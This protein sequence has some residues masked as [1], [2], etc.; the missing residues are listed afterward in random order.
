LQVLG[1][2]SRAVMTMLLLMRLML[3]DRW[4]K[5]QLQYG[6]AAR[7]STCLILSIGAW[8]LASLAA[9][10]VRA[11]SQQQVADA[12][13]RLIAA[14]IFVG[15]LTGKDLTWHARLE[16]FLSFP[17]S[18]SR[19]YG[20]ALILSLLTF[21]VLLGFCI[22]EISV[23]ARTAG[24]SSLLFALPAFVLLLCGGRAMVSLTRT[25]LFRARALAGSVRYRL[26]SLIVLVA[27]SAVV[28]SLYDITGGLPGYQYSGIFFGIHPRSTLRQPPH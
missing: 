4:R 3:K 21:P 15:V 28:L 5:L 22:L 11:A 20:S 16:R 1:T 7:L 18:F 19:L 17:L 23:F 12:L 10:L 24:A 13:N 27:A 2:L 8:M 14:W 25:A 9:H 6:W 26:W